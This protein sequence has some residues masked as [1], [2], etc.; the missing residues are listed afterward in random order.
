[1]ITIGLVSA[2]TALV[3]GMFVARWQRRGRAEWRQ[4]D[5]QHDD[6]PRATRASLRARAHRAHNPRDP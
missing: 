4:Y 5:E 2:I 1:M 3:L 6:A